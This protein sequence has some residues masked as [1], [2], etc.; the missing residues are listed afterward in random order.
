MLS[1][2]VYM[3][4]NEDDVELKVCLKCD[5]PLPNDKG[6][7]SFF[8]KNSEICDDCIILYGN[9]GYLH[10]FVSNPYLNKAK[11][12]LRIFSDFSISPF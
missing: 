2:T 10:T 6:K 12:S 1:L 11:A 7:I 8:N 3:E 9:K 4:N 5:A